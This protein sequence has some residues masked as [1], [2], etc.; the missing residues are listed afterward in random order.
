MQLTPSI[1]IFCWILCVAATAGAQDSRISYIVNGRVYKPDG[2]GAALVMVKITGQSGLNQQVLTDDMGRFEF[3]NLPRGRYYLTATNPSANDQFTDPVEVELTRSISLRVS[4]NIYLR[5]V[6]TTSSKK[7]KPGA[8]SVAEAA[9]DVPKHARKAYEQA[10]RLRGGKQYEESL[11]S[12][13]RSIELFPAYFQALAERGHLLIAMGR[14]SEAAQDF[15]RAL[16]LNIRYGPA[17]RGSG[18]CKFQQGKYA[19]AVEEL[20]R[21]AAAEPGNATI[22]LFM[23]TSYLAL[24]RREQARTALLKALSIDASG[25]ARAHVHL[26]NLCIKENRLQD[27]LSEIDSY[28]RAVPNAPDADKL[29]AVA[30]QLRASVTKNE[31]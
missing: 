27:A 24:D 21:A 5:N 14:P 22:Y 31:E 30:A 19:E 4:A 12:F 7:E 13:G 25:A 29:R 1:R 28:L 10:M 15:A 8:V 11:K 9:Q 18:I 23:G 6:A 20:E 3:S 17:L 26:A 2:D 16:E